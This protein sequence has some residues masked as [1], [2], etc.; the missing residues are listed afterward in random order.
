MS[1]PYYKYDH[2]YACTKSEKNVNEDIY[3]KYCRGY[4]YRECP[5]YKAKT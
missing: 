1:C 3:W 4:D 5:W 2:G